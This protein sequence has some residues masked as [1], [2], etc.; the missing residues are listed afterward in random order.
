MKKPLAIAIA[1][2]MSTAPFASAQNTVSIEEAFDSIFN[3][4][5]TPEGSYYPKWEAVE[6]IIKG[7]KW[8]WPFNQMDQ[9]DFTMKG[10]VEDYMDVE[11]HSS[12]YYDLGEFQE[13]PFIG[14]VSISFAI[15]PSQTNSID[16]DHFDP[17]QLT[18]IPT[19]CDADGAMHQEAFYQWTKPGYTPLYIY[20]MS[21]FGTRMGNVDY[22][23]GYV[24]DD[25]LYSYANQCE[26]IK[27]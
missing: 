4:F 15:N 2:I 1:L 25:I 18:K 11:I 10:T 23:I 27:W 9:H 8:E 22:H 13:P 12:G 7:V 24:P 6:D 14:S 21:S 5:L 16:I 26:V 3:A 20:Y 17:D 19:T